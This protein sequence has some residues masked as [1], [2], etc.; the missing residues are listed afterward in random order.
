MNGHVCTRPLEPVG[1]E[2][3][4]MYLTGMDDGCFEIFL[5]ALF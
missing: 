2:L 3:L 5:D 4:C 1:G